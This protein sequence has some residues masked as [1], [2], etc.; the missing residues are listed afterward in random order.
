MFPERWLHETI[1]AATGVK[2]W[3]ADVPEGNLPPFVVFSRASTERESDLEMPGGSPLATFDITVFSPTY[4]GGKELADKI[5]RAV[6]KFTGTA[7]GV[8]IQ[9]AA[10][11][12]ERDGEVIEF[13]G[14]G[15]PVYSVE[16]TLLVRF[17]EAI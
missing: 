3:P 7:A 1:E 2:A 5:R 4:L 15:K 8:D 10:L 11:I 16:M 17:T 9:S 12:D 13:G 14:E 6:D